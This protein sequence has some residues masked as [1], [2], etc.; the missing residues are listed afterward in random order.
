M[1]LSFWL[2]LVS[3]LVYGLL[4]SLLASH[5]IKVQARQWLG[6]TVYRRWYRLAFN[7]FAII[8]F[9][10]VLI[11]A[12]ALP[13]KPI[14]FIPF[15]WYILTSLVQIIAVI[16]LLTGLRQTGLGDFLGLKQLLDPDGAVQ[17][18]LVEGGLYRYVRHPLYTAGL[19]FI[20]LIPYF[21]WNLLAINLGLT[22][23]IIIGAHFEERKMLAEYG[24]PYADYRRRTPMLIPGSRF[25]RD[26][27]LKKLKV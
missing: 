1:T 3:V 4:H 19:V 13:D 9:V 23:Y 5:K 10:P 12:I 2:I 20:W 11:F 14:Y 15:P 17:P 21:S 6:S 16:V 26:K 22:A 18:H 24:Q 25:L 27:V 8:S 7:I